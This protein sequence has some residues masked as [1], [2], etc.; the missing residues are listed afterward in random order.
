MT[1][2][3][4]IEM[5]DLNELQ[6]AILSSVINN[7]KMIMKEEILTKI[8]R[9]ITEAYAENNRDLVNFL[10]ELIRDLELDM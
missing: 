6:E 10:E 1:K 7:G 8:E 3:R 5:D 9:K 2:Y 4:E